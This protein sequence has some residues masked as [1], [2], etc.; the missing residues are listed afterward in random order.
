MYAE[1]HQH[2]TN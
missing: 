2:V 1:C